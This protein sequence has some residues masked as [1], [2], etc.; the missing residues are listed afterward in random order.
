[1]R[2]RNIAEYQKP[3]HK[4][5]STLNFQLFSNSPQATFQNKGCFQEVKKEKRKSTRTGSSLFHMMGC[6]SFHDRGG[7]W[8]SKQKRYPSF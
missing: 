6:S 4:S 1:M 7:G 3:C 8:R 5:K 2:N